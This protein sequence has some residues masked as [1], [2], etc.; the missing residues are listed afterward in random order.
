MPSVE[1]SKLQASTAPSALSSRE[2]ARAGAPSAHAL[3]PG[4]VHP[5]GDDA[6]GVSIEV[7]TRSAAA[8]EPSTPPLDRERVA[9]I[10]KALKEDRYPLVPT[11]IAD[12]M[13]AA[14]VS[15]GME[16]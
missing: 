16:K 10:R 8:L 1:L 7:G 2:G 4:G 12:A 9:E 5:A 3:A 6:R 15:L 14:R 13:I 11:R